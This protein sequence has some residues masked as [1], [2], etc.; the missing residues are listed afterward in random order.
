M[1]TRGMV[2]YVS[3]EFIY[4]TDTFNG[5]M[6]PWIY[7]DDLFW[8]LKQN[9]NSVN[10]FKSDMKEFHYE[11]YRDS[12]LRILKLT[13]DWYNKERLF[14]LTNFNTEYPIIDWLFIK[15]MSWKEID[16]FPAKR[17]HYMNPN[18]TVEMEKVSLPSWKVVRFIHWLPHA[19]D[20]ADGDFNF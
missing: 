5:E 6:A 19:N 7:W 9:S 20:V 16:I 3:D 14:I 13:N 11:F 4:V 15:N 12:D 2:V 17:T 8:I 18:D 1:S 10:E